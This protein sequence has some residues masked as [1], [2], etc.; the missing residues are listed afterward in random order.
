MR[1]SWRE[2][3]SGQRIFLP[4]FCGGLLTGIVVMNIG[5][6]ILLGDAGLLD[7]AVL[8]QMK[9]MTVDSNALFSYILRKRIGAM[10]TL[11]VVSTTYLGLV[12]CM[13]SAVWYGMSAG[14]FLTALVLRYGIKGILLSLACIFPQYLLYVPVWLALLAWGE[15]VF[16]GIYT[17]GELRSGDRGVLAG[18]A[19]GLAVILL[20]GIAGCVLEGYVNP[21]VLF[22][23]LKIF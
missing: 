21:Y 20:A 10:L 12:A 13:G 5:K 2:I 9:Y 19:G 23:Y 7:E 17:R 18:K 3:R 22:G 4:F 1:I 15:G 16:R 8:Y 11:A 14:A 6:S